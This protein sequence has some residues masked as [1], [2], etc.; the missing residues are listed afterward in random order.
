V[1]WISGL[2]YGPLAGSCDLGNEPFGSIK[3]GKFLK[4]C[5]PWS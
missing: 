3:D 1:D 2:G 4:D 5:V